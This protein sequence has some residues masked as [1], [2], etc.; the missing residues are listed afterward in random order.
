[1]GLHKVKRGL[2]LPIVG[3]PDRHVDDAPSP[4]SVALVAA[5]YPGMKPQMSVAEGDSVRLGQLLFEDKKLPGVRLTSPG[6]GTVTAINRGAKRALQSVVVRL[7]GSDDTGGKGGVSF[8]SFTG[9]HPG[10]LSRD[11]VAELLLE[12]G[13]WTALRARPFGRVAA[14]GTVPHAIFVTA[15]DSQ[16]LAPDVEGFV[17]G[18]GSDFERGMT[19]LARLTDGLVYLCR[20]PG[21]RIEPP[22]GDRFRAEDFAG[23]HPAG[24]PGLHIHTLAPVGRAR[25]VWYVGLQDVLAIGRLFETGAL[26]VGRIVALGGPSVARPRHL[27]TRLG[28]SLDALTEGELTPV[29]PPTPDPAAM[30]SGPVAETPAHRVI[31]GSVLSGRRAMGPIHGYLGR[32]HQQISAVPEDRKRELLGWMAPGVDKFSVAGLFL[33]K[34]IPGKRFEFGTSTHGSPRAIVPIGL[35]EKVVPLDLQPTF[36]LKSLVMQD[37]ERAEELGCLELEEDDLALCTFVDPGK[38][39]YGPHLRQVLTLIE[40]EG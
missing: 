11:E 1:M 5:D 35:Y 17:E 10:S 38:I 33:S 34:L 30:Q 3:I 24:T 37:I 40:K 19:A 13:L 39:E 21:S 28:A 9:S 26:D 29:P 18:R 23:P 16:P 20:R 4:G 32:Y 14:P 7:D 15:M 27:R 25:F 31:S 12:S 6:T 36:L 22:A 8:S 2:D